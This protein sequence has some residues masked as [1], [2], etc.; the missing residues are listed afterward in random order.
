M[1]T[2]HVNPNRFLSSRRRTLIAASTMT[3][4]MLFGRGNLAGAAAT[5]ISGQQNSDARNSSKSVRYVATLNDGRTVYTFDSN[6]A[7]DQ[8][9]YAGQF[10]RQKSLMVSLPRCPFTV[11]F[12]PDIDGGRDEVVVEL[13]KM[14]SGAPAH[15]TTPYTLSVTK[16]GAPLFTQNVQYHWWWSRWRWQSAP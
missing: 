3:A 2:V 12:R 8:G 6:E 9:V 4:G 10:V 11:F 16:D 1:K 5:S 7:V 15:V 13:G 14:W